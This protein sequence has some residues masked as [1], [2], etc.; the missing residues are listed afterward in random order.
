MSGVIHSGQNL[1]RNRGRHLQFGLLHLHPPWDGPTAT[2]QNAAEMTLH[3]ET[4]QN[5][6]SRIHLSGAGPKQGFGLRVFNARRAANRFTSD[7]Q[8]PTLPTSLAGNPERDADGS[9][10]ARAQSRGDMRGPAIR[11]RS[12]SQSSFES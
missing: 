5:R 9:A 8:P 7:G 12:R 2:F 10:R 6:G 4:A 3:S 1:A 11:D